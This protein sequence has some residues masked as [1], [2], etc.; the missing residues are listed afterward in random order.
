MGGLGKTT[1]AQLVY[2]D[3][4]IEKHFDLRAWVCASE[5]F[6]SIRLT[7][8]I[9]ESLTGSPCHLMNLDP[10][11]VAL[12]KK[13]KGK[14]F[15]L[16]LDN[17]WNVKRSDWDELR[18]PLMVGLRGSGILVTTRSQDVLSIM[19]TGPPH[20]LQGLSD[21]DCWF[22]FERL[23]FIDG[24][25]NAHPNLVTIG[26]EIVNKCKGLPLAVKTLG[27]L[28][29]SKLDEEEWIG[30]LKSDIWDLP[31][32]RNGIL[33]AL[34][35]SYHHLPAHLKQ[36]FAYCSIFPK[37]QYFKKGI[38]VLLW[39]AE[40]FIQPKGNNQMEDIGGEYLADLASRSFFR[41]EYT[42]WEDQELYTMHDLLHD[43]AQPISGVEYI[44]MEDG[45]S[46]GVV[47]KVRH[48][49][50]D[51]FS[52]GTIKFEAFYGLKSLRTL[53]LSSVFDCIQHVPYD[54]FINLSRLRVLDLG[55][56]RIPE[57]PDSIGKL[58]H[59]RYLD[60]SSTRIKRLPKSTTRLYNLQTLRITGCGHIVELPDDLSNLVNLR[61]LHLGGTGHRGSVSIPLRIGKLTCL[62][63]LDMFN[64]GK[65]IGHGINELKDMIHL[66][67]EICISLLENVVN[68]EE[69][70][71]AELKSKQ[72]LRKLKL[73]WK[74]YDVDSRQEGTENVVLEGLQP[75]TNL[76]VLEITGYC[77]VAFPRWMGD[78]SFSNLVHVSLA[79]CKCLAL[80]PFGQL[81]FLKELHIDEL[82][83]L[84]KMG[85]ELYGDGIVKGFP[86]L[87]TL[88]L[89]SMPDWEEWSGEEGDI[90]HVSDITISHCSELRGL[91]PFPPTLKQLSIDYC[92]KLVSLPCVSSVCGLSL[93][94]C[95]E[96][97]LG[98]FQHLTSLSSLS[99]SYFP[100]I[101]SLPE[102]FFLPLTVLE[103][104]HIHWFPGLM[105]LSEEVGLQDI[106][107]LRL[108]EISE[109]PQLTSLGDEVLPNTLWSLKISGCSNLKCLPK[110]LQKLVSFVVL[111]IMNCPEIHSLP[112]ERLPT[113][114]Q[115]LDISGCPSLKEKCQRDGG[116]DWGKIAHIPNIS[117]DGVQISTG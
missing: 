65:E 99:I 29:F 51:W 48:L 25:S 32:D 72:E 40:G 26:K 86:S 106:T 14:K 35:L 80:P 6:D 102:G 17:V 34:R 7:R 41:Y 43:L 67:G 107:S 76:K 37:G 16:V 105:S 10:L 20:F 58:I 55:G 83:G 89:K 39:M 61:H 93:W 54:L 8:A 82:Y 38:L 62:Q 110:G 1:L 66:R 63:T 68:V 12:V 3:K 103:K 60:L 27:G 52:M 13:L 15:L 97:I 98:S 73:R 56:T 91:P 49:S 112:E 4:R 28:L 84:K 90:S 96:V 87:E 31:E 5:D 78:S 57:L 24:N 18:A 100:N 113:T 2:N 94:G 104:L 77:S 111:E 95:D 45:K 50:Y 69:V 116:E 64:V 109:C 22:L 85:Q 114:L 42:N 44:R 46:C 79:K 71:E 101:T 9:V 75:D 47:D 117:I 70:K 30:I 23:A 81:P 59:L 33:P 53:L 36:C 92:E 115:M 11:Q 74:S 21:D 19:G 88:I 108:L